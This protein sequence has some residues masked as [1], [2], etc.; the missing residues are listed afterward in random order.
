[1]L[2]AT[3]LG[4]LFLGAQIIQIN[5]CRGIDRSLENFKLYFWLVPLLRNPN[6]LLSTINISAGPSSVSSQISSAVR[7]DS[8]TYHIL[9]FL[10]LFHVL[11]LRLRRRDAG[12]R[13]QPLT[14]TQHF[15]KSQTKG[16][17]H[18]QGTFINSPAC[19]WA[20]FERFD[21]WVRIGLLI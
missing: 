10:F 21:A 4:R 20:L 13:T 1:M 14:L 19:F 6:S 7:Q 12:E 8:C 11:V 18:H 17:R 2:S 5:C 3:G 9:L 16:S 15:I